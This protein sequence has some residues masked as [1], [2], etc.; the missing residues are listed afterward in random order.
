MSVILSQAFALAPGDVPL[1]T[2]IFGWNNL[3][4]EGTLEATSED[5]DFPASNLLN[6]STALRWK[7]EAIESPPTVD[8]YLTVTFAEAQELDYLAIAV[9]N[10]GTWQNI[11]SVEG[12]DDIASPAFSQEL[13]EEH[14]VANDNPIIFRFAPTILGGIRLRIQASPLADP[15]TPFIS[16]MH[17]GKLLV[18]PRGTHQDHTPINLF[19]QANVMTGK[20]E[21]GNFL[22]R[23]VLSESRSTNIA[24]NRLTS[25]WYRTYMAPF[26]AASKSD[27]FF[28]AH[29]PQTFPADV[30]Y[31]WMTNDPQPARHFDT[32]TMALSLQMG[33]IAI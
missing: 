32:G 23:V 19:P 29:M 9:H 1:D 21:T 25:A 30:G 8:Q 27:P 20:S 22:G 10:F 17:V 26:I 5:A 11:L 33:G 24:F 6:S 13:V 28:F 14:L 3:L 31:C 7:A 15:D 18:M 16:V 2:P 12:F 4:S